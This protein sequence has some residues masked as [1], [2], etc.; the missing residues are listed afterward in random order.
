VRFADAWP[1]RIVL[2]IEGI[3]V[4]VIGRADLI[5]NK[6]ASG[7]PRDLLDVELLGEEVG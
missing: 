6:R 4:P 3:E 7:R 2:D 1:R 5:A